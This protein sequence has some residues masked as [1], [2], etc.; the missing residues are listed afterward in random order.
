MRWRLIVAFIV[1]ALLAALASQWVVNLLIPVFPSCTFLV[2]PPRWL[3]LLF[4]NRH[5][6][7]A[8]PR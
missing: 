5:P 1:V 7:R 2:D 3:N 8:R 6:D 4:Y